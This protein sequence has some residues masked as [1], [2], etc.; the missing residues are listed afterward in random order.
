MLKDENQSRKQLREKVIAGTH[1]CVLSHSLKSLHSTSTSSWGLVGDGVLAPPGAA[2]H[3]DL[4]HE[5]P[6]PTTSEHALV[7]QKN[8]FN[9]TSFFFFFLNHF[10]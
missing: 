6:V 8:T 7:W 9:F 5:H 1:A 2:Q 4:T 3:T 10:F